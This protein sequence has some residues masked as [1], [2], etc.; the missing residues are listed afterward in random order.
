MPEPLRQPLPLSATSRHSPAKRRR[1]AVAQGMAISRPCR[2]CQHLGMGTNGAG[3]M[4]QDE[5]GMLRSTRHWTGEL[6]GR[7]RLCQGSAGKVAGALSHPFP[8]R[9]HVVQMSS[10]ILT[11]CLI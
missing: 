1:V 7:H 4:A 2:L 8:R 10:L 6:S 3:S 9:A 11:R 5:T